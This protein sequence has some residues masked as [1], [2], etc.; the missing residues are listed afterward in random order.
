[1]NAGMLRLVFGLGI[2]AVGRTNGDYARI[3][4][5]ENPLGT[6]LMNYEDQ[7]KFSQ[8]DVDVLSL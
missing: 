7:K 2:R 5:I 6:P 3:V 4:C 1:M 8:H